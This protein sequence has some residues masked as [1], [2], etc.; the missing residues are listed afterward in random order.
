MIGAVP[1]TPPPSFPSV[2]EKDPGPRGC[3]T[4]NHHPWIGV[5]FW[6]HVRQAASAR[7]EVSPEGSAIRD[8]RK[9]ATSRQ[10][11]VYLCSKRVHVSHGSQYSNECL[12][13]NEAL[14]GRF[15]AA[16]NKTRLRQAL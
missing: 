2:A 5:R 16:F 6:G 9:G 1:P 15:Q 14:V 13:G 10:H 8:M 12:A 3:G 4:P 7:S 11:A